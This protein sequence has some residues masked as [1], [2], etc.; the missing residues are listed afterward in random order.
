MLRFL[1]LIILGTGEIILCQ[2][3]EL[4]NIPHKSLSRRPQ[5]HSP[6]LILEETLAILRTISSKVPRGHKEKEPE[7]KQPKLQQYA[8][9]IDV[10]ERFHEILKPIIEEEKKKPKIILPTQYKEYSNKDRLAFF[11]NP[12]KKLSPNTNPQTQRPISL[13]RIMKLWAN[14]PKGSYIPGLLNVSDGVAEFINIHRQIYQS[15]P[16]AII[17]LIIFAA[18]Q[19]ISSET[20][21]KTNSNQRTNQRESLLMEQMTMDTKTNLSTQSDP[22]TSLTKTIDAERMTAGRSYRPLSTE[23]R[24]P[25]SISQKHPL[26]LHFTMQTD[27]MDSEETVAGRSYRQQP[28]K[29]NTQTIRQSIKL[30]RKTITNKQMII[31]PEDNKS[32][33]NPTTKQNMNKKLNSKIM[34]ILNQ[35]KYDHPIQPIPNEN[36]EIQTLHNP[37]SNLLQSLNPQNQAKQKGKLQ[38]PKIGCKQITTKIPEAKQVNQSPYPI[39]PQ[40]VPKLEP[41]PNILSTSHPCR[42]REKRQMQPQLLM[43]SPQNPPNA[44][45]PVQDLRN[46]NKDPT[47][48]IRQRQSSTPRLTS[49]NS[50]TDQGRKE[51][52]REG[53]NLE[54]RETD[55]DDGEILDSNWRINKRDT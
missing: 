25:R 31:E 7:R 54:N 6:S 2:V 30:A 53:R 12:P 48:R 35:E 27:Q 14:L 21:I 11:F 38:Y 29:M 15:I 55:N 5:Q 28:T 47:P 16:E 33:K 43:T 49:R 3:L 32:I 51:E 10:I 42:S 44:T 46:R 13:G 4:D 39:S 37:K 41:T 19:I 23:K 18:E 8:E 50:W 22:S 20:E 34:E 1:L 36:Q 45:R 24:I 9:L 17:G 52:R 26:I 40:R